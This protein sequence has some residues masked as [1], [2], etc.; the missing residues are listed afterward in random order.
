MEERSKSTSVLKYVDIRQKG[1][2]RI[3]YGR[4]FRYKN[5][6]GNFIEDPRT[7]KRIEAL[8]I[9]PAWRKVWICPDPKGHIQCYGYDSRNR[10]QYIYHPDWTAQRGVKKFQSLT[11]LAAS[12]RKLKA[13]INKDLKLELWCKE[14]VCALALA[15]TKQTLI[16][17]GNA[18]YTKENKSYGLTTLQKRHFTFDK[19][20]VII[21]YIGKKGIKQRHEIVDQKLYLL[22]QDLY[23]LPGKNMFKYYASREGGELVKLKP[24][25]VNG[26]LKEKCAD[27]S[28]T[29]KSFRI[30]GASVM[31]IQEMLRIKNEYCYKNRLKQ[32]NNIVDK[33]AAVLG[34]TREVAKKYYVHP[35]I[36]ELFLANKLY[37]KLKCIDADTRAGMAKCEHAFRRLLAL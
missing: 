13:W 4:K 1:Y 6:R 32:L 14:K 9:P 18:R 3:R 19:Q 7:L 20:K 16:R 10:K 34:N 26:Y 31:A 23:N 29:I 28:V 17:V 37:R 25:D 11:K 5:L 8:V 30:W 24:K 15:L 33:V 12:L 2:Q 21:E 22:L 36:Q 27:G 35:L